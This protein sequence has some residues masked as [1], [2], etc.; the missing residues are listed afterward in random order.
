MFCFSAVR[1][2]DISSRHSAGRFR[3]IGLKRYDRMTVEVGSPV[4]TNSPSADCSTSTPA[5][6]SS[7]LVRSALREAVLVGIVWLIAAIWSLSVCYLYGYQRPAA[8][9]TL[10]LGFPDW[11]FWGIVVP[12]VTCAVA[13]CLFGAFFVRDGVLGDEVIEDDDLGLGG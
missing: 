4:N 12:W 9:I 10:V 5:S 2:R 3:L 7:T 1:L 6:G 8:A 11:V 13:S